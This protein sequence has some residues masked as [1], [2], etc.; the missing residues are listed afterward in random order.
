MV[1]YTLGGRPGERLIARLGMPV[2]DDTLLRRVK[3]R[4]KGH[5][6]SGHIP[7]VGVDDWA[8]PKGSKYGTILID[9]QRREVADLL[10]E[11]SANSF[12]V[13]LQ[14]HPEVTTISR[15]RQGLY[16]RKELGAVRPK[17][18][19]WQTAFT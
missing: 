17:R 9:L 18:N 3:Q 13:W 5:P 4:A 19:R 8:W 10:P 11:R 16:M 14:K 12:T 7:V 15:D 2:S 6:A 1:G